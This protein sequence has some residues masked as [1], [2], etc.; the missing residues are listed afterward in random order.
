[1]LKIL[2]FP[3]VL[4]FFL[5][6]A[7][8]AKNITGTWKG[9][10]A[11]NLVSLTDITIRINQTG[12]T[13]A[14]KVRSSSGLRGTISGSVIKDKFRFTINET[15]SGCNGLHKGKAIISDKTNAISF[16]FTGSNCL[17]THRGGGYVEKR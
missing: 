15:T 2:F 16:L 6:G 11:S 12:N 3:L 13:F 7:V 9:Y 17:G 14:G 8:F 5:N 10:F 4:T 1:M